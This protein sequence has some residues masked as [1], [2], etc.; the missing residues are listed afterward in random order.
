MDVANKFFAVTLGCSLTLVGCSDSTITDLNAD[1]VGSIPASNGTFFNE[2]DALDFASE[3]GGNLSQVVSRA[4]GGSSAGLAKATPNDD[5]TAGVFNDDTSVEPCDSGSVSSSVG[6]SADGDLENA[7]FVFNNCVID[8]Q[9]TTGS[10]SMIAS[11]VEGTQTIG[12]VFVDFGSTGVEGDSFIDGGISLSIDENLSSSI[13]GSQLT[14]IADDET[15]VFSD[16]NLNTTFNDSASTVSIG[17][18]ATVESTTD[19]SVEFVLSPAFTGSQTGNPTVGILTMTHSDGSSLTINANTGDPNTYAYIV[20]GNGTVT[21]GVG[22]WADEDFEAPVIASGGLN[23][24]G[25]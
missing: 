2:R 24:T 21:T 3:T 8:G 17:G 20:N 25:L 19:G 1:P 12:I 16:F 6:T 18:Q 10:M 14:M 11:D 13:S 5:V 7:S 22:M 23:N 15:T 4:L 9:T